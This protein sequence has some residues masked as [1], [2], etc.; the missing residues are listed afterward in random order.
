M[1]SDFDTS[2]SVHSGSKQRRILLDYLRSITTH[3]TAEEIHLQLK[4]RFPT[5]GLGTIYRNLKY[6]RSHGYI[7]EVWTDDRIAHYSGRVDSH[8]HFRCEHCGQIEELEMSEMAKQQRNTLESQGYRIRE[9]VVHY[10]GLCRE[11]AQQAELTKHILCAAYG[12][13][14]DELPK[15]P[16]ACA[17]CALHAT[18]NYFAAIQPST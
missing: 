16:V 1:L 13:F 14:H 12:K 6:L 8:V 17:P 3:P 5:M 11:C 2:G 15:S 9:G 4:K 18:C 10:S 7:E